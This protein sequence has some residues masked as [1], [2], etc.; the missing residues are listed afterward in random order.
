MA[1]RL[2]K[3]VVPFG[4]LVL[5]H[6]LKIPHMQ[7]RHSVLKSV[8]QREPIRAASRCRCSGETVRRLPECKSRIPLGHSIAGRRVCRTLGDESLALIRLTN[9]IQEIGRELILGKD[10]DISEQTEAI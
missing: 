3:V 5:S 7:S 6:S 4:A 9:R 2:W 10:R 1:N 8:Q